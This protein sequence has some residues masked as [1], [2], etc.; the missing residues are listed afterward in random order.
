MRTCF[1]LVAAILLSACASTANQGAYPSLAQRDAERSTGQFEVE[2]RRLDVPPV[3]VN[4]DQPLP[5]RLAALV[6]QGAAAHA[7]FVAAR[8]GAARLAQAA[9][10]SA[11]GSDAW[12]SAQVAL[13]DLDSYRS[14]AA[15]ALGELDVLFVAAS[16]AAEDTA[17]IASARDRVTAMIGDEDEALEQLRRLVR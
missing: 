12:A 16:V 10:G 15:V 13:A 6:D 5:A 14:E 8:P 9:S 11:I 7:G 1:P 4:S 17:T 3:D 2:Q